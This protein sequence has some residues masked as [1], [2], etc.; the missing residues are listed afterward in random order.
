MW[1]EVGGGKGGGRRMDEH[2]QRVGADQEGGCEEEEGVLEL[3]FC[4]S[5]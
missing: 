4:F 3:H 1:R 2:V 5:F